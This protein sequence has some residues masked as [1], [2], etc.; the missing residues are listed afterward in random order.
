VQKISGEALA[1]TI[2]ERAARQ[3]V[4]AHSVL[5]AVPMY[6]MTRMANMFQAQ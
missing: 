3:A 1:K 5:S 6:I 4:G 2:K